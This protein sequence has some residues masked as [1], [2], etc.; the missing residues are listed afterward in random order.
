MKRWLVPLLFAIFAGCGGDKRAPRKAAA[1]VAGPARAE[2]V[3]VA[4]VPQVGKIYAEAIRKAR[5]EISAE[6]AK[7]R[8]GEIE[9]EIEA[10]ATS[11]R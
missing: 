8:L 11:G 6:N 2:A 9:R 4:D 5:V 7:K 3:D 10:E 1:E